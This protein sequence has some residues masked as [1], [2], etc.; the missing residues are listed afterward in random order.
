M[1]GNSVSNI[2]FFKSRTRIV[3]ALIRRVFKICILNQSSSL[4]N[5]T[6]YD[7]Q[8]PSLIVNCCEL[9]NGIFSLFRQIKDKVYEAY[10]KEKEEAK[11]DYQEAVDRGETAGHVELRYLLIPFHTKLLCTKQTPIL[12]FYDV[13]FK[14]KNS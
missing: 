4:Q 2:F 14:E 9:I 6:R 3:H 8:T 1:K 5:F 12:V 7:R 13:C 10:V 11:K